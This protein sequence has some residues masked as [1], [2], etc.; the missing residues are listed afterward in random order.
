MGDRLRGRNAV[1]T[2]AGR[3]IGRA[4][5]LAIAEEGANVVVC[6]SGTAVDGIGADRTP[7]DDVAAQCRQFGIEA[8]PHY[9]DVAHFEAAEDMVRTC[10]NEFGKIDILCNIA[11]IF[12]L[13]MIYDMSEEEWDRVMNVHVKGTFNLTRHAVALMKQQGYGRIINC[14][15]VEFTGTIPIVGHVNYVAAK[16]GIISL[17]YATAREMAQ[18]GVTCNAFAPR[19]D[20]RLTYEWGKRGVEGGFVSQ[21]MADNGEM[22]EEHGDPGDFAPFIAYLASDAAAHINGCVF[23]CSSGGIGIWN[24]PEIVRQIRRDC[25]KEGRWSF[26]EIERLVTEELLAP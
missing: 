6:D 9:G 19:A 20:T 21:E 14:S 7:A 15:S 16:G 17:T 8:L 12:T 5:A 4:I 13:S 1:V 25:R 2:G 3:G 22:M 11:G 23:Y 18:Y 10:A 26:E 24:R